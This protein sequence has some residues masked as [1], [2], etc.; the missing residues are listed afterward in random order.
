MV[1]KFLEKQIQY[2]S[3]FSVPLYALFRCATCS[4]QSGLCGTG[5]AIINGHL[6]P[7]TKNDVADY[8]TSL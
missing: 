2:L 8:T 3:V 4:L 6:K 5:Y 1:Q 7:K